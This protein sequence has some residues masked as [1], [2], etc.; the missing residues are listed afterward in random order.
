MQKSPPT[1]ATS[2]KKFKEH[3]KKKIMTYQGHWQTP[4][5]LVFCFETCKKAPLMRSLGVVIVVMCVIQ[6]HS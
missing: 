1:T 5:P 6:L 2:P 3:C 4:V